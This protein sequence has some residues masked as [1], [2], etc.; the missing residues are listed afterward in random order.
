MASFSDAVANVV[1]VTKSSVRAIAG[2]RV[3]L[4]RQVSRDWSKGEP[5]L[6]LVPA[7]CSEN[8]EFLDVGAN[9]GVYSAV[10]ARHSRRVIAM[11]PNPQVASKLCRAL[12]SNVVVIAAAASDH[13]G[14]ASLL[15]PLQD[16]KEVS[17]RG[18]MEEHANPGFQEKRVDISI[19]TIDSLKFENLTAVKIDV[20]GHEFTALHGAAD[21]IAR[22]RPKVI[23]EC[24]ERHNAG[25]VARLIDFFS[26]VNYSGYFFHTDRLTA[27][28]EFDIKKFQSVESVKRISDVQVS[29]PRPR[30]YINNFVFIPGEMTSLLP[31]LQMIAADVGHSRRI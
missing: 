16:G 22:F 17:T 21:T 3:L 4:K 7:F 6:H 31:Q 13:S 29:N 9:T 28:A 20:E 18:S 26:T 24:E 23:V 11:E 2:P 14:T 15:V 1:K 25:G 5:E 27:I 19:K 10:A 12:P 8:G 30:E